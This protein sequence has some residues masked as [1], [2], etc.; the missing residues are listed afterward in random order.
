M[1]IRHV[2]RTVA[3]SSAAALCGGA[4]AL[5]VGAGEASADISNGTTTLSSDGSGNRRNTVQQR[6]K[7]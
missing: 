4:L 6:S 2:F 1:S 5:G 3:L 7:Y